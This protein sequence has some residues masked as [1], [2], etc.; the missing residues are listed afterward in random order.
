M[1]RRRRYR[2]RSRYAKQ[3]MQY[4]DI[5]FT[6]DAISTTP[7]VST[8]VGYVAQQVKNQYLSWTRRT[9][10]AET[11]QYFNTLYLSHA[12]YQIRYQVSTADD[13]NSLR[14]FM[15]GTHQNYNSA[16]SVFSPFSGYDIDQPALT[17]PVTKVYRDKFVNVVQSYN[18]NYVPNSYTFKGNARI[19]KGFRIT[20]DVSDNTIVSNNGDLILS[21]QSDS[22][23][24]AHPECFGFVR[25]YFR[26][27]Q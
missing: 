7:T 15:C 9:N 22:S 11:D 25:I 27:G 20:Y 26:M 18:G 3:P 5:L 16:G 17:E 1:Y 12:K 6:G 14:F 8:L 13:N 24:A 19:N 23:L 10:G 21:Q 2:T 4:V